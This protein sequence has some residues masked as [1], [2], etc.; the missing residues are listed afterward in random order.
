[1]KSQLHLYDHAGETVQFSVCPGCRCMIV[2]DES[3]C[4]RCEL[5]AK[6]IYAPSHG[7]CM[8][9]LRKL[10]YCPSCGV[11][12]DGYLFRGPAGIYCTEC[13]WENKCDEDPF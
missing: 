6:D 12:K 11:P 7:A 5:I 1:M 3:W 9:A 13:G 10:T 4:V 8:G 2:A